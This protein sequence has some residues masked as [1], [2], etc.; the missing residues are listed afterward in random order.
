[1]EINNNSY[2][3]RILTEYLESNNHRKTPERYAILDAVYSF[4]R[5]FS[6][7]ELSDRVCLERKFPVSR[8][9][10]YNCM[11]LFLELGLVFKH[12]IR[13]TIRYEAWK[14]GDNHCHQ[15]CNV[16]G[17]VTEIKSDSV[18]NSINDL[19]LRRFKREGY[20][21][22]I[23]GICQSCQKKLAMESKARFV[24]R[25]DEPSSA[26]QDEN[27]TKQKYENNNNE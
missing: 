27:K 24:V 18:V 19:H 21:L 6:L 25:R 10:L 13:G 16:C 20:A 5:H 11:R 2:G 12:T 9:T 14:E 4:D 17:K 1:M 7:E 3:R 15:I 23:Y 22:Y 26:Q 8:A